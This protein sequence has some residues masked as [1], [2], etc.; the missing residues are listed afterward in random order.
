MIKLYK[1]K[2]KKY[3]KDRLSSQPQLSQGREGIARK[4][5]IGVI[6]A[7]MSLLFGEYFRVIFRVNRPIT[8]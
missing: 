8:V 5:E 3:F 1:L 6:I 2:Y 4:C 7:G